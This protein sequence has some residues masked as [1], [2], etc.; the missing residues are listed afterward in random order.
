[1]IAY[2]IIPPQMNAK[3]G[4]IPCG[5]QTVEFH[6]PSLFF[7]VLKTPTEAL[8]ASGMPQGMSLA[9]ESVRVQAFVFGMPGA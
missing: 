3:S 4:R 9:Q 8:L 6:P 2:T 5:C 7:A 1:M